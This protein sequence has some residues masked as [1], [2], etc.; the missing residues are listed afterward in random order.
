MSISQLDSNDT[1]DLRLNT[2]GTSMSVYHSSDRWEY[3]RVQVTFGIYPG[4]YAIEEPIP[5]LIN[6]QLLVT[7]G[8]EVGELLRFSL[9]GRPRQVEIVGTVQAFPSVP[10]TTEAIIIADWNTL[11]V[12]DLATPGWPFQTPDEYWMSI[13]EGAIGAVGVQLTEAPFSSTRVESSSYRYN[14]LRTDPVALARVGVLV[15]GSIVAAIFALAGFAV[16]ALISTR[17]RL[18]EFALLRALGLS[19]R[20][21]V[22]SLMIEHGFLAAISLV[23]GSGLGVL[24]A[25]G[26]LPMVT[27]NQQAAVVFPAATVSIPWL[28]MGVLLVAAALAVALVSA[29]V[30]ILLRRQGLGELLRIGDDQT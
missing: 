11:V 24:L 15:L 26:V 29:A 28:E 23:L 6:Q 17:E 19:P 22:S 7:R 8:L 27:I 2:G 25:I 5:V 9:L 21:L 12:E 1:I 14:Q 20:Q 18:T 13:G 4:R 3:H 10:V 16:N 30:A